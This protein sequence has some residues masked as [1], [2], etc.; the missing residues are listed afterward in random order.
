MK[1]FWTLN[2]FWIRYKSIISSRVYLNLTALDYY[3][4]TLAL[5]LI[6]MSVQAF[7]G[8]PQFYCRDGVA[9][10]ASLQAY[11]SRLPFYSKLFFISDS[12]LW[13]QFLIS[14]IFIFSVFLFFGVLARP[15][16]FLLFI[17]WGNLIAR[18]PILRHVGDSI[19]LYCLFWNC[20]LPIEKS[21]KSE[22]QAFQQSQFFL[23]DFAFTFQT[24]LCYAFLAF[25]KIRGGWLDVNSVWVTLMNEKIT[26]PFG[27]WLAHFKNLTHIISLAT[28]TTEF[29]IPI[30]LIFFR[31]SNKFRQ[32]VICFMIFIHL[33]IFCALDLDAINLI[34]A[35]A[36]I[37]FLNFEKQ[38]K[39]FNPNKVSFS[40]SIL[41]SLMLI[42]VLS[43][44]SI[45][46][47]ALNDSY[48]RK[49]KN[50]FQAYFFLPQG[51]STFSEV[52]RDHGWH[53][54]EFHNS[55]IHFWMPGCDLSLNSSLQGV[56]IAPSNHCYK[57]IR[58]YKYIL[59]FDQDQEGA[60]DFYRGFEK[61]FCQMSQSQ[62]FDL[63]WVHSRIN[64]REEFSPTQ[65]T[66]LYHA[67]CL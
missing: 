6:A 26:T 31:A 22:D 37:P 64:H 32:S 48:F 52:P 38:D 62:S 33:G 17:L 23:S 57:N 25:N 59:N 66:S 11:L 13:A 53:Y 60:E 15:L 51:W 46:Q 61:Y 67:S 24:A 27:E 44:S 41:I 18:N 50:I 8:V 7:Q 34:A 14:L 36:L 56:D 1:N 54:F 55:P 16:S 63:W 65:K 47:V 4:R 28:L 12:C 29:S 58:W 9:P 39:L 45:S 30:V 40:K 5:V 49:I 42:S 43:S 2:E 21:D 35:A 20:I 3:R 10:L 19:L